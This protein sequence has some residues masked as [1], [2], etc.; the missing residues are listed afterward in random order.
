MALALFL[1]GGVSLI[2]V[3][4]A[5]SIDAQNELESQVQ[6]LAS[7]ETLVHSY[8]P[9]VQNIAG[10][11]SSDS[12]V[13]SSNGRV[14]P[15]PQ[16]VPLTPADAKRLFNGRP[17]VASHNHVVL[18]AAAFPHGKFCAA[19]QCQVLGL[20]VESRLNFSADNIWYFLIAAGVS[21]AVAAIVASVVSQR[22]TRRVGEAARAARRIAAGDLATRVSGLER[23]T[24][25]ELRELD[26]SIN[27]MAANLER[28]RQGEREFLLAISHEFRTP[29]TSI[30]GYSEAITEHA[31]E[32]PASAAAVVVSEADRLEHLIGDLLDLARLRARQFALDFGQIDVASVVRHSAEALR[33]A[34]HSEHLELVIE[35]PEERLLVHADYHRLGQIVANLLENA[36][37]YARHQVSISV[38]RDGEGVAIR[39]RD[40]G[41][42]ISPEDLPFIFERLFKSDRHPGRTSGSGLGL[43]IVAE[44]AQAMH[45]TVTARS[46]VAEDGSGGGT[47]M[48][49][50]FSH[51]ADAGATE[52]D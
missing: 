31:V 3:R 50:C 37:K 17:I 43:A 27:T 40:D 1:A 6:T 44:L 52:Q 5:Q 32:D 20:Y 9:V 46:P 42:G 29:L 33:L 35:L 2:L 18:A 34:F 26:T 11:T 48:T 13:V 16:N 4:H 19:G 41:P 10:F 25:P 30:R 45:A 15:I 14:F 23:R 22:I 24:Y 38:A 8:L 12:I 51:L 39:V 49:V 7:H 47:E 21:L 28:A 36:Q